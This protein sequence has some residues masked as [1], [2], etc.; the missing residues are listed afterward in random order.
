MLILPKDVIGFNSGG[1]NL[2]SLHNLEVDTLVTKSNQSNSGQG[3]I[4]LRVILGYAVLLSLQ[5]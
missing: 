2:I 3:E 5:L 4:V 1:L